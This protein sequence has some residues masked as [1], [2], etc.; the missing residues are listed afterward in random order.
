MAQS[1]ENSIG[2]HKALQETEQQ[3]E[4]VAAVF[5]VLMAAVLA[6][7]IAMLV[8][9]THSNHHFFGVANAYALLG[10]VGTVLASRKIY[11]PILPYVFVLLDFAIVTIA[12]G[13]LARM[14]G[15]GMSAA[16]SLPLFSLAFVVLIHAALRYRPWLIVFAAS[17]C[18]P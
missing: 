12:L 2:I 6:I 16:L 4:F 7:S 9:E 18:E 13:M 17:F 14:H 3:G 1:P 10:L 11:H 5:R 8:P 15:M